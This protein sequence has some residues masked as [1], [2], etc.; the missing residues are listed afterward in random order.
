MKNIKSFD[1]FI[2]E[3]IEPIESEIELNTEFDNKISLEEY[4]EL[5]RKNIK[6]SL[7]K[8]EV[9]KLNLF[10]GIWKQSNDGKYYFNKRITGFGKPSKIL[11]GNIQKLINEEKESTFILHLGITIKTAEQQGDDLI[12]L[13]FN[14]LNELFKFIKN[15]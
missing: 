9:I 6:V 14:T 2:N 7:S 11:S 5:L 13:K 8:P 10:F 3:G 15:I 12:T 4:S 1:I